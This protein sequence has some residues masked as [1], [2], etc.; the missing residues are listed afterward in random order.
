A[1]RNVN[2][3]VEKFA[4]GLEEEERDDFQ[5]KNDEGISDKPEDTPYAEG[6]SEEEAVRSTDIISPAC[7]HVESPTNLSM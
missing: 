5:G 7:D 1:R 3:L 6:E 2:M 4:E